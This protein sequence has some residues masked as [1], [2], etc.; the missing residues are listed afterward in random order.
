MADNTTTIAALEA[1]L[2]AGVLEGQ[3]DGQ[4]VRFASTADIRKRI[5]ELTRTDDTLTER[6]PAAASIDLSGTF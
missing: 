5:A 6:R 4:R 1:L 2:N 3:V